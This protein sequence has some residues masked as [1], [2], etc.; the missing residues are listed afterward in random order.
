M[1]LTREEIL[2]GA[3]SELEQYYHAILTRKGWTTTPLVPVAGAAP[4]RALPDCV[5]PPWA[6]LPSDLAALAAQFDAL[7]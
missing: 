3:A 5:P 4:P 7:G 6:A 1:G 2:F